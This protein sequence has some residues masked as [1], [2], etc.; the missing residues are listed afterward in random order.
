MN[1]N[2]EE[3]VSLNETIMVHGSIYTDCRVEMMK[4]KTF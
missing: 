4:K 1:L 2:N 3:E